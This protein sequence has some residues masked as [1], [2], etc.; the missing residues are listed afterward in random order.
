MKFW[1]WLLFTIFVSCHGQRK[2][3]GHGNLE[4]K[5]MLSQY[6]MELLIKDNYGGSEQPEN[7]V[8]TDEKGLISFFSKINRTRKPGLP[9][10]K[11]DF[12]KEMVLVYCPGEQHGGYAPELG[13]AEES[14]TAL[15]FKP[16]A[17]QGVKAATSTALITPFSVYKI[18]L[19]S[20]EI[21]FHNK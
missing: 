20:K 19:T 3:S 1:F 5:K 16:T 7:L 12:T 8:I 21:R 2:T 11:V 13:L 10:P 9:V 18:P 4:N 15:I 6:P 17:A 14:D